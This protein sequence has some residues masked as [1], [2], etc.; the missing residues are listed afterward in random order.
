MRL[1]IAFVCAVTTGLSCVPA[2]SAPLWVPKAR[3]ESCVQENI[4]AFVIDT[5]GSM[6]ESRMFQ[7]LI[8]QLLVYLRSIPLDSKR[9]RHVI[10]MRFDL[11]ADV[12]ID[13]YLQSE[14]DRKALIAKLSRLQANG[15]ATNFDEAAKLIRQV[16][17][18]LK[19]NSSTDIP[20][21]FAVRVFSDRKPDPSES[22]VAFDLGKFFKQEFDPETQFQVGIIHF[23]PIGSRVTSLPD[24]LRPAYRARVP[25]NAMSRFLQQTQ[26]TYQD[27]QAAPEMASPESLSVPSASPITPPEPEIRKHLPW[28]ILFVTG[29]TA[30]VLSKNQPSSKGSMTSILPEL[31][32]SLDSANVVKYLCVTESRELS[33]GERE[34]LRHEER[35]LLGLNVPATFGTKTDATYKIRDLP[36]A[37]DLFSITALPDGQLQLCVN[38]PAV[39]VND[40]P[41]MEKGD[42]VTAYSAFKVNYQQRE[43]QI[44]PF[45]D[46][47]YPL[48]KMPAAKGAL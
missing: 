20:K 9:C 35:V 19:H 12:L 26:K 14:A 7:P 39:V 24:P 6:Q 13:S 4:E 10:L 11:T 29:T 41:A 44:E 38:H 30:I 15:K 48:P 28:I 32:K 21:T 46:D 33:D 25:V 31:P 40:Q 36:G 8:Q 45:Y 43:W 16:W 42:Q 23:A 2:I 34:I 22:K 5:S 17:L 37:I 3:P 18:Q 47:L 27:T 1:L